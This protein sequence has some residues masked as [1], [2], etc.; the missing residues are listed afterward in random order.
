MEPG[1]LPSGLPEKT[2]YGIYQAMM[3]WNWISRSQ[4]ASG[5]RLYWKILCCQR[6]QMEEN[7]AQSVGSMTFNWNRPTKARK[8]SSR[9]I[10]SSLPI[11]EGK[12]RTQNHWISRT[13]RELVWWWEG[14][15]SMSNIF[16]DFNRTSKHNREFRIPAYKNSST[17]ALKK[18]EEISLLKRKFFL[19]PWKQICSLSTISLSFIPFS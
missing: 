4:M 2:D 6:A 12:K 9:G 14:T 5:L 1:L 8:Y 19:G 18:L 7:R 10:I 13:L 16:P 11:E 15:H 17:F 3:A